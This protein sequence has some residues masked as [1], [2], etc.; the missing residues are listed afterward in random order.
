[1][2]LHYDLALCAERRERVRSAHRDYTVCQMLGPERTLLNMK[3][4]MYC[5]PC[6]TCSLFRLAQ[7]FQVTIKWLSAILKFL[8]CKSLSCDIC[9]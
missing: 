1:M 7:I 2:Q 3:R 6:Y 4:L 8:V 5:F 9:I